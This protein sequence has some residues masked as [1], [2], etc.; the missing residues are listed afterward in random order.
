MDIVPLFPPE[1][2]WPENVITKIF[3]HL[4]LELIIRLILQFPEYR[5]LFSAHQIHVDALKWRIYNYCYIRLKRG[6]ETVMLHI[7]GDLRKR[8][9]TPRII[10]MTSIE[11]EKYGFYRDTTQ[12][13]MCVDEDNVDS[14]K[15]ELLKHLSE[16]L[17]P[18]LNVANFDLRF[19]PIDARVSFVH[20]FIFK[21][22]R[23]FRILEFFQLRPKECETNADHNLRARRLILQYK[24]MQ[25]EIE[26]DHLKVHFTEMPL[27]TEIPLRKGLDSRFMSR[28]YPLRTRNMT[29]W[30]TEFINLRSLLQ[31]ECENLT[32]SREEMRGSD[33]GALMKA[34]MNGGLRKLKTFYCYSREF[35]IDPEGFQGI[36]AK[37]TSTPPPP[38]FPHPEYWTRYA[39]EIIRIEDG[40]SANVLWYED[41][42]WFY[43]IEGN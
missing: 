13:D 1:F 22:I 10:T 2:E 30:D 16:M 12:L 43:I 36:P 24:F 27:F 21:M 19:Y 32:V 29:I 37:P 9:R 8:R 26:V 40:R 34:W 31:M 41:E 39:L 11:F 7:E 17:L 42:F 38:M 14:S 4:P 5:A 33:I 6:E 28:L 20:C 25:N 23:R 35:Q 18:S 15:M 3:L